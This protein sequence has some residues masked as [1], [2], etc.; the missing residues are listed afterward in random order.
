MCVCERERD[1]GNCSLWAGFQKWLVRTPQVPQS[2]LAA[3]CRDQ[4]RRREGT[5]RPRAPQ[6]ASA[7]WNQL[8]K[9]LLYLPSMSSLAVSALKSGETALSS[10]GGP[11]PSSVLFTFFPNGFHFMFNTFHPCADRLLGLDGQPGT[12]LTPGPTRSPHPWSRAGARDL[13]VRPD[14]ILV[15]RRTGSCT[16]GCFGVCGCYASLTPGLPLAEEGAPEIFISRQVCL[17]DPARG[18]SSIRVAGAR[19]LQALV[20]VWAANTRPLRAERGSDGV[21]LLSPCLSGGLG[22]RGGGQVYIS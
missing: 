12:Q 6:E 11:A 8:L 17:H 19:R 10:T 13:R 7:T 18:G 5:A 4:A 21:P 1:L 20:T 15:F 16:T 2:L 3:V 22:L 14:A 9:K